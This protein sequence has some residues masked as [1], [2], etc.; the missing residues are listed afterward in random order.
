MHSRTLIY[1][2]SAG[3]G[4]TFSLAV[5]YIALLV[6]RGPGEFRATLAVTFTNKATAEMKDR[7]LEQLY[8]IGN[9]L[10]ES[11]AYLSSV[12]DVL[13]SDYTLSLPDGQV[14]SLCL[15]ALHAIL[16]NYERFSVSTIDTFFQS[17]LRNMAHELGLNARLQVDI[18][19][20]E[21]IERA[22][23]NLLGR[24]QYSDQ[25]LLPWLRGYINTQIAEGNRWDVRGKLK[26]MARFLF[27]E[28]YLRRG[29]D[30]SRNKPFSLRNI[31]DL[32]SRLRQKEEDVRQLCAQKAERFTAIME[33]AGLNYD[34]L[35]RGN[36]LQGYVGRMARGAVQDA[37]FS[38][39][40]AD[41][42]S[43]PSNMLKSRERKNAALLAV[44]ERLAGALDELHHTQ[45]EVLP[46]LCSI[47][48]ARQS[49]APM[50]ALEAI[51]EEITRINNE[52][53]RFSLAHTPILLRRM[54][55]EDDAPFV[56]EKIG[57]RYENI[58]ID[59][60]Q[61][62]SSLQWENFRA[63]L[64]GGIS[65]G[66]MNMVVG[67]V[68]QSIYR[69]RGGDWRIL[70]Q[71]EKTNPENTITLDTNRRSQGQVVRFNNEFFTRAAARL[72]QLVPQGDTPLADLY[73]GAL[74]Q[75][76][77]GKEEGGY[78]RVRVNKREG[79]VERRRRTQEE[80]QETASWT[81]GQPAVWEQEMLS[82]MHRQ[83]LELHTQY[84][85]P[86]GQ[87][88]ILIRKRKYIDP[89]IR[90]FGEAQEAIPLVSDEAFYLR[91]SVATNMLISALTLLGIQ[92][93]LD[94]SLVP[95][96]YL[97]KHY[98]RDVLGKPSEA[99]YLS[100]Q[101]SDVLPTAFLAHRE[102]LLRLPLHELCEKLYRL[103]GIGKINGQ[104]AYM[105]TFFD[106]LDEFL[107]TGPADVPALLQYWEETMKYKTIPAGEVEGVRILTIHSAK[108]LQ[109]HTVFIPYCEYSVER[110]NYNDF[111][112]CSPSQEPLG[113]LGS[114]PISERKE[115]ALS[116]FRQDYFQEHANKRADELNVLYVA[117]TRAEENL[118][119]WGESRGE[120]EADKTNETV[121]DLIAQCLPL[122]PEGL[123][124]CGAPQPYRAKEKDYGAKRLSL[125]VGGGLVGSQK[126]SALRSSANRLNPTRR[127]VG[128][129]MCSYEG[130]MEFRQSRPARQFISESADTGQGENGEL[131]YVERGKLLHY[132]FS[133]IRTASDI[134]HVV[135]DMCQRGIIATAEE[136]ALV[137]AMAE[138]GLQNEQVSDWFSPGYQLF[139]ECPILSL[140]DEAR[141]V[142]RRPDRVM[143]GRGKVIV[144]D[145]KFGKPRPEYH[146][147]VAEYV[148]LLSAMHPSAEV[149]GYLWYVYDNK[150]ESV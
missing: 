91:Y 130:K 146:A 74:Q 67:D 7:I 65:G 72:D 14:R 33:E 142:E 92:G 135:A 145:F 11:E 136:G 22:I 139:T 64:L 88:A 103:L 102:R 98:L 127:T 41:M 35:C 59:E 38:K 53:N 97:M 111:L 143:V 3:S 112:W 39:T 75:V 36:L 141:L 86:Y 105:L 95:L 78:V 29:L 85:I 119:V 49:L 131:S 87:M 70:H 40:L 15:R 51:E 83:M 32:A 61:D 124:S 48:P 89:L 5:R 50:G 46:W 54:I 24:L 106:E 149:E 117:F 140:D 31:Q 6:A 129:A 57:T 17:V 134:P 71:L 101:P 81:E 113:A 56:F 34:N 79:L 55:S 2:A 110:N 47:G 20:D 26:D 80:S 12:Q 122:S 114:L 60:F 4:K 128:A 144:V 19:N 37:N 8:G 76:V 52:N 84:G 1:S 45:D 107:A 42:A 10:P 43:E 82:D 30:P 120:M 123:Y 94:P 150:I 23:E 148:A 132:I 104:D 99:D 118:L 27:K 63:L 18:S 62:T 68:K 133:Q 147:Q 9:G 69:W 116:F 137:Q 73:S 44:A 93:E 58:M 115:L 66:G 121:G 28:Q 77:P 109:Y 13:R 138:A 16:H 96:H 90:F 108:G 25:E 126:M 125:P 100:A 21:I